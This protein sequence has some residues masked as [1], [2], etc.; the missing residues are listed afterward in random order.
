MTSVLRTI[1]QI[2]E[3]IR[4]LTAIDDLSGFRISAMFPV[5]TEADFTAAIDASA[6]IAMGSLLKD[7]GRVVHVYD[8]NNAKTAIW[9]QVQ[10][11]ASATTEGVTGTPA[12]GFNSYYVKTWSADGTG[13]SVVRT[14]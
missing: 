1:P 4:F 6:N 13:I 9:R 11:V 10:L 5:M 2:A 14:G 8:I 12:D 7:L 3:R